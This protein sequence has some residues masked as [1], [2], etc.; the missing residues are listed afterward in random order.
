MAEKIDVLMHQ[1]DMAATFTVDTALAE[2]PLAPGI[3]AN[4]GF[5]LF[6]NPVGLSIFQNGDNILV[7]SI[8]FVLPLGFE[9]A[10]SLTTG[11]KFFSPFIT[12]RAEQYP[13]GA[14]ITALP[15]LFMPLLNNYE[16]S[17]GNWHDIQDVTP[18]DGFQIWGHLPV[19]NTTILKVSMVN[20]PVDF[21]ES[22]FHV[23]AFIKVSHTLD[24]ISPP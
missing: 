7:L 17:V 19:I 5:S 15:D 24:L 21:D 8:G 16:L 2:V 11:G 1:G 6:E 20:V 14:I 12:T 22:V 4:L 10:E 13:S 3:D 9:L 23:P 18:D